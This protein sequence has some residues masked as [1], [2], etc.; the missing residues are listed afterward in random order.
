MNKG[1]LSSVIFICYILSLLSYRIEK[2]AL[3]YVTMN[4]ELIINIKKI[5]LAILI[6]VHFSQYLTVRLLTFAL[7]CPTLNILHP[8]F[9]A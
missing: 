1:H 9:V 6:Y 8:M 5:I 2:F 4:H 3:I 7:G